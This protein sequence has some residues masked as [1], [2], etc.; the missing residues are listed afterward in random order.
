M[1]VKMTEHFAL[2]PLIFLINTLKGEFYDLWIHPQKHR[3]T[4]L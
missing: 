2:N 1:F 3:E 4:I